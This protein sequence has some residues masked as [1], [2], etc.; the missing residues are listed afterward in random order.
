MDD[1]RTCPACGSPGLQP[2]GLPPG[3]RAVCPRCG[4]CWEDGGDGALVDAL[5]CPGCERRGTCESCP[6]WLVE[7]RSRRE[8]LADGQQVLIRPLLYGDRF[9]LAA[10]F[11]GLS[12]RSRRH[13]FFAAPDELDPEELEYLT[14]LDYRDHFACAAVLEDGP[15]PKGVGVGRYLREEDDPTVAEVAVTVMDAY[16]RRGVG[17]LLTRM[18]GEVAVEN[19][20]RT[21][22]SYVQWENAAA[23]ELLA[24]EGSRVTPAEPGVAR[25]EVRL[26]A[27]VTEVPDS[28]LHRLI[29]AYVAR[30]RAF[31][32]RDGGDGSA[33]DGGDGSAR[34]G[35]SGGGSSGGGSSGDGSRAGQVTPSEPSSDRGRPRRT[36]RT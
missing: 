13:R 19:G 33:R 12:P 36:T 3:D 35:S 29:K 1:G 26:P 18:L 2:A 30:V 27:R 7:E 17:T 25:I 34:D 14:N 31:G 32:R 15:V 4:R 21:F 8:V 16:Q 11:S 10:G 6:T 22:V 5:A 9:E 28:Y 23:V 24:E 20:I